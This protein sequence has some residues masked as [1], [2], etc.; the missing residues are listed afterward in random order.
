MLKIGIISD[1]HLS[2][3]TPELDSYIKTHFSDIEVI[4]HA[5]D[6]V[7]MNVLDAFKGKQ[8]YAVCGNMD[9]EDVAKSLPRKIELE[10]NGYRIGLIHGW[11]NPSDM[12]SRLID[13][14]NAVHCIVYG[15]THRVC[16]EVYD[17]I[18]FFNPGSPTDKRFAPFNSLGIITISSGISGGIIRL[19]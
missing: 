17:G 5:G 1:T 4:L 9:K 12:Q 16:N 18:L 2:D 10:F 14:F 15:H 7:H 11:G 8:I 19:S 6:L 13:E 3:T